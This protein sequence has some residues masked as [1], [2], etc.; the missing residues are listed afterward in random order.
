M[1]SRPVTL[2]VVGAT[3]LVGRAVLELLPDSD[4]DLSELR[5]LASE[6]SREA[7]IEVEGEGEEL[8]VAALSAGAFRGV[9]LA[10]FLGPAEVARQWAPRAVAEGCRVVDASRAFRGDPAVPL[11]EPTVS[12]AALEGLGGPGI[13]AV[14]GGPAAA[15]APVLLPLSRAA[16]LER[17]VATALCPAAGAGTRGPEQLEREAQELMNGREPEEGGAFPHRL[18]FNL[19]PQVGSFVE[20][21]RTD[22]EAAASE[23]L[24]RL[25]SAPSLEVAITAVRVPVFYGLAVA[26][27][28]V[29]ARVLDVEAARAALREAPGLKLVDDLAERVYP[30]PMLT[31]N[32]QAVLAGR[33]RSDP[34]ARALDLFVTADELHRVAAAALWTAERWAE[35]I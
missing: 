19:V 3:G 10:L 31:A 23:D 4:L 35:R 22:E 25:L 20:G 21:G 33:L 27:Q 26:V 28:V 34:A 13:V 18:A 1:P 17:V 30:M 6:R 16:G 8:P 24:R 5:L 9:D 2:A 12:P 14:A 32:D 7:R 11:L 15:L 29:T